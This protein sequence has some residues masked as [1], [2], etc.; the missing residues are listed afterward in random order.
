MILKDEGE[1][2]CHYDEN[3]ILSSFEGVHIGTQQYIAK[4]KHKRSTWPQY[5]SQDT[6]W[7]SETYLANIDLV[8]ENLS[9]D[10]YKNKDEDWDMHLAEDS[11]TQTTIWMMIPCDLVF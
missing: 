4:C 6:H 1:T 10:F 2:I 9:M 7:F 8:D 11:N 3:K 5:T